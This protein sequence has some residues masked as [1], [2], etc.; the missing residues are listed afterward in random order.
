MKRVIIGALALIALAST[1]DAKD[2]ETFVFSGGCFWCTEADFEKLYGVKEVISGFTSGSTKDPK[3]YPGQYGDHR[4]AAQVIYDPDAVSFEE[5]VEH[6]FKTIDYED[7]GGQFCDR[8]ISYSPA[9]YV[10]TEEQRGIVGKLAPATSIVPIEFETEFHPVREQHQDFYK[11]R[12]VRYNIYRN[13]CGRDRRI[14]QLRKKNK[15]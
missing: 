5:L 15:N 11:K 7:G 12:P 2:R 8:G 4:E 6:V 14:E 3:Y 9:I 1:A 13:R 10:K